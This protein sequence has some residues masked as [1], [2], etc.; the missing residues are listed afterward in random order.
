M[1]IIIIQVEVVIDISKETPKGNVLKNYTIQAA[2]FDTMSFPSSG[3]QID[4][5][6][7]DVAHLEFCP[8]SAATLGFHGYVLVG[9]LQ[10]PKLWSAEQVWNFSSSKIFFVVDNFPA[11]FV[12]YKCFRDL[13]FILWWEFC[14]I[15][16]ESRTY[17]PFVLNWIYFSNTDVEGYF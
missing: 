9:K 7:T 11:I 12:G 15:L 13:N 16:L 2:V 6:S 5:L 4:L 8:T 14:M 10:T 1:Y 3:G 17:P